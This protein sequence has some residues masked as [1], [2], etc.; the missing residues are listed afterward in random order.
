[1]RSFERHICIDMGNSQTKIAV[2]SGGE[3]VNV[4]VFQTQEVAAIEAYLRQIPRESAA[5]VSSTAGAA[6]DISGFLESY[7]E[8]FIKFDH[9]T[10]LP[11]ENCYK[12]PSSLGLDRLAAV[13]AAA[14]LFPNKNS[15]VVDL[16][17]A[18][19]ID[20]IDAE[21][22]YLGGCISPGIWLRFKSLHEYTAR[23]PMVDFESSAKILGDTT[24]S[25][26]QSGIKNGILFEI[27]SYIG[28]FS[29]SKAELCVI[30][31]GGDAEEI[32]PL[33]EVEHKLMPHL[34]LIGLEKII[35]YSLITAES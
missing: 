6:Y 11:I 18:I 17:T 3:F 14:G 35:N 4:Q 5:I 9:Q 32:S 1:M 22:R 25:A 29:E 19:T 16:G 20:F 15:L 21:A 23:L 34:V 27:R 12:T 7:F 33:I 26:I 2:F 24:M 10:P 28:H 13:V 8:Y 31:T 30:F